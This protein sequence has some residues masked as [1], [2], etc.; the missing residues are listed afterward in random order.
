[1]KKQILNYNRSI[2]SGRKENGEMKNRMLKG[3]VLL[4]LVFVCFACI[5]GFVYTEELNVAVL[6]FESK[7]KVVDDFALGTK[8]TDLLTAELAIDSN[9]SV[10]DREKLDA[11]INEMTTDK[12]GIGDESQAIKIGQLVGAKILVTGR[13]FTLDRELVMIAKI[14]GTETGKTQVVVERGD[15]YK[16]TGLASLI[17]KLS[18]KVA[19]VI[20]EKGQIMIAKETKKE[21]E[22]ILEVKNKIKRKKLPKVFV[23]ISER[24]FGREATDPAA[25]GE[26]TYILKKCDF[27]VSSKTGLKL[28]DWASEYIK[29]TNLDIPEGIDADIIIVGEAFSEFGTRKGS[30]ISCK[31]RVEIQVIDRNTRE[32][33]AIDRETN[34][35]VDLSEIVAAKSA[36][37]ES[38]ANIAY[39]IIPEFVEKWN[40]ERE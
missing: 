21:E 11:I 9:I 25:E 8:I 39:R 16:D 35:A 40:S 1:M 22:K 10:V 12:T 30:L 31:S 6:G 36:I 17:D 15:F 7:E 32:V 5:T 28:T 34:A 33:L 2:N 13:A 14:I 19:I 27:T 3:G 4:T 26:L 38:A 24:H 18:K 23:Y 37:Q 20:L 29:N